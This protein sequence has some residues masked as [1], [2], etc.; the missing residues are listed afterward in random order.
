MR[1]HEGGWGRAPGLWRLAAG[2]VLSGVCIFL[3]LR[4]TSWAELWE[5]LRAARWAWM[6]P[7]VAAVVTGTV[8][9]A[10]RWQAL[11]LPER[12]PFWRVWRVFVIGQMLNV[13]L[14]ARA[15][16][17]GRVYL[18]GEADG[19]DRAEAISTLVVEK[20]ADL[21]ML[22]AAYVVVALWLSVVEGEGVPVW[23][24]EVGR[25]AAVVAAL[26]LAG[27]LY[28][29]FFGRSV[30]RLLD[31]ML[32]VLPP[33]WRRAGADFVER[34][35]GAFESLR[36]WEVNVRVGGWSVLIW[37]LAT[38]T[39]VFLFRAFGLALSPYAAL[40]LLVMLMSGVA[41]PP[42]PG[43]LGVFP[44]VCIVVLSLFGVEREVGL[45]YGLSLQA[46][47]YL[48]LVVLGVV[49]LLRESG[50]LRVAWR[51]MAG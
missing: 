50:S 46:V 44:Y 18:I 23:L 26:A 9:K 33:G 4:G 22:A 2:V 40:F 38:L 16:E 48:P 25:T 43:N 28:V 27:L 29:A 19:V 10:V 42:L 17:V 41:V 51:G 36:R 30:Q 14:P 11:F 1:G 34:G 45:A 35:M 5:A 6:A 20:V 49:C 31:G 7:G 12:M 39:N 15:G 13:V 37:G 8:V 3:A 32:E 47:V 21:V 24:A